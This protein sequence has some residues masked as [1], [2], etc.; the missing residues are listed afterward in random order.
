M[1]RYAEVG[2]NLTPKF[3]TEGFLQSLL[4]GANVHEADLKRVDIRYIEKTRC[5]PPLYHNCL[6][7]SAK[8]VLSEKFA[9]VSCETT[10]YVIL[11]YSPKAGQ[12]HLKHSKRSHQITAYI[13]IGSKS[14]RIALIDRYWCDIIAK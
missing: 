14:D 2:H 12:G 9:I 8:L 6:P 11:V 10:Y 4:A 7:R 1:I 3:Q 5:V 13:G